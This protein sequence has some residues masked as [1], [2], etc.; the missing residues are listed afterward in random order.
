M[1]II[2]GIAGA[3]KGTQAGLL[4]KDLATA[5]LSSGEILRRHKNQDEIQAAMAKGVLVKDE[6]LLPIM[7]AE[8][9]SAGG[10]HS[11]LILDGFP[12]SIE[13]AHWI[14][15]K[16]ETGEF[17]LKAIINLKLAPQ[18][19]LERLQARSRSDD[20]RKAINQRFEEYKENILP[21]INYFR[22]QGFRVSD[23]DGD[24]PIAKV[25]KDIKAALEV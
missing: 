20:N 25:A 12:R 17:S 9:K 1:I 3:G 6:I 18:K 5:Q 4:A 21:I 15:K 7:E 8:I 23:I 2:L 16:V 10:G 13:Q 22:A 14:M 24:Q 11:Q 19:A